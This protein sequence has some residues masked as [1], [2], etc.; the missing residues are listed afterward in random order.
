MNKKRIFWFEKIWPVCL[1]L[2]LTTLT[3]FARPPMKELVL[4]FPLDAANQQQIKDFSGQHNNGKSGAIVVSNSLSLVSMQQT[5]QLTFAVWIKPNSIT[6]PCD[7]LLSKGG[8]EPGG[9]YG[10]YEFYLNSVGDND[11]VFV[12]GPCVI[13]TLGSNGRWVNN[14]LGEWIQVAFTINDQTK[15]AKFYVNGQPTNDEFDYGTYFSSDAKLNFDVAN[16]LYVGVPD[17]ASNANRS[18][19]DGSMRDLMLFNRALTAE[20][21]QNIY[22]STKPPTEKKAALPFL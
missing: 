17:P 5:R 19:F 6:G 18:K 21:I 3:T 2:I 12:S 15:T 1:L 14:H 7:V 9:A 22:K 13:D 20:E 8:N 16:N 4:Y 11:I 10:G